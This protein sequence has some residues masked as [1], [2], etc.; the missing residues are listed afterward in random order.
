[1]N[2]LKTR[3]VYSYRSVIGEGIF[4]HICSITLVAVKIK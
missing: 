4:L 1:M 2:L 3:L